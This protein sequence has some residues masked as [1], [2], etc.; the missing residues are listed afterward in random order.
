MLHKIKGFFAEYQPSGPVEYM[1]VGLGNPGPKYEGTRHNAGFMALDRIAQQAGARVD[2]LKFRSSVGDCM[3][4]GKRTLLLKPS[5]FMNSSG[6]AVRDAM[7]FY[8]LPPERVLILLDDISLDVGRIR[9]RRKGSD[10]GQNGM[11]SILYLCG[12]DRF[13]RVKIGIGGKPHPD[14]DLAAWV[15]SRFTDAER[16]PL[17]EALE[18]AAGAAALI[19][20]GQIDEAMNRFNS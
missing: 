20:G 15:L 10:G 16:A 4:S 1:I 11:K 18:H 7:Q 6:E 12:S 17:S 14:Y 3:L 2:R 5:T 19:A 9:I 8:K 13:P